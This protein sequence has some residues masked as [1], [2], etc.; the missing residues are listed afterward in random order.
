MTTQ[1]VIIESNFEDLLRG[2]S[3]KSQRGILRKSLR[4]AAQQTVLKEARKNVRAIA[5]STD[6]KAVVVKSTATNQKADA[7]IGAKKRS[8]W[9]KIGHLMEKGTRA[10]TVRVKRAGVMVG[11]KDGIIYGTV[12]R[13][14]GAKANPWMAP[15]W[16]AQKRPAVVK[17]GQFIKEE[18]D[19]VAL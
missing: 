4:R 8:R 9:G 13:N 6:A 12:V 18:I 19:K 1:N 14:P 15:A 3:D 17:F 16:A 10:H 5:G 2:L 7:R 11:R